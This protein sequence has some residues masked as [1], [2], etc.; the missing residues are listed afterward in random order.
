MTDS[1][2]HKFSTMFQ[3]FKQARKH[4][5]ERAKKGENRTVFVAVASRMVV[6]PLGGYFC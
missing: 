3:D 2:K 5:Q 1:L 4:K 6:A